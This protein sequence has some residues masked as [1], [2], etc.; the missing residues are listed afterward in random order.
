MQSGDWKAHPTH[1]PTHLP[2]V[3]R[4][5]SACPRD[6]FINAQTVPPA[7]AGCLMLLSTPCFFTLSVAARQT[8]LAE[9]YLTIPLR[10]PKSYISPLPP[11]DPASLSIC[12]YYF[13]RLLSFA[14]GFGSG[15]STLLSLDYF[16]PSAALCL[17]QVVLYLPAALPHHLLFPAG[18]M[19][20]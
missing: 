11:P 17:L 13:L 10:P 15:S 9:S 3:L 20:Y 5:A 12:H 7:A 16:Y 18:H 4:H 14:L 6:L 2:N 1:P 8:F 19:T